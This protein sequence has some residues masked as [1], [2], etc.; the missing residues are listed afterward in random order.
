MKAKDIYDAESD[1][2]D[3]LI[4]HITIPV[5]DL[6]CDGGLSWTDVEPGSTVTGEF[7]VKNIGDPTS[8]L[9]WEI[10]EW[11]SWGTWTFTPSSGNDLTPEDGAITVTV[12]VVAPDEENEEFSGEVKIVNTEDSSDFEIISVSLAT[13]VNQNSANAISTVMNRTDAFPSA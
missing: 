10:A 4:V 5:P 6:D 7:T 1:W 3:S 11:P 2:S 9:D 8:L 12:S 13:P